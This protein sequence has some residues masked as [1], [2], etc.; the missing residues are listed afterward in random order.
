[1]PA[2][3]LAEEDAK[4]WA[5]GASAYSFYVPGGGDYVQ[6]TLT[7]DRGQLHFEGRHNYE[8]LDTSSAWFGLNYSMGEAVRFDVTP[9]LGA[10][11]GKTD[12]WAPGYKATLSWNGLTAYSE[13]EYV[14]DRNT[15]EDS[16]FYSWNELTVAPVD[17]LR[18]GFVGQRTRLYQTDRSIQRGLLVGASYKRVGITA[19]VFNPDQDDPIYVLSVSLSF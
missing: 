13:G 15:K 7:A 5:F 6:P 4:T 9:M 2:F 8:N 12:G 1:M 18:V 14:F 10:V 17:W 3:A 16:F 11:V 19:H